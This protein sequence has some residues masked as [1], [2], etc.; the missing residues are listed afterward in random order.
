M[1]RV[2]F[3][4]PKGR[5]RL[6]QFQN[7]VQSQYIRK[8]ERVGG[9]L[10]NVP[11]KAYPLVSQFWS[12]TPEEYLKYPLTTELKGKLTDCNKVLGK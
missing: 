12:W 5:V 2:E 7:V 4:S 3:D 11:I 8:V 10:M 9:E 6:D 1:R